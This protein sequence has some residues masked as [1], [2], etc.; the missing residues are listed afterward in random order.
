MTLPYGSTL[1]FVAKKEQTD[2]KKKFL[3]V[4]TDSSGKTYRLYGYNSA[5]NSRSLLQEFNTIESSVTEHHLRLTAQEKIG[6]F[7]QEEDGWEIEHKQT[8]RQ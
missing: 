8:D 2:E 1:K 5:G 7:C 4:K 6:F 3:V